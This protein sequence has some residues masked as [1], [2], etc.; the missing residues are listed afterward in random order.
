[1][2]GLFFILVFIYSCG[3]KDTP[4]TGVTQSGNNS[5][6]SIVSSQ[7]E[8][9]SDKTIIRPKV[10]FLFLFDNS[11][12]A[13][14]INQKTKSSLQ[15]LVQYIS[16]RFDYHM[17]IFPLLG[18]NSVSPHLIMVDNP[19]D[20]NTS[21]LP[22]VIPV[23]KFPLIN[24]FQFSQVPGSLENGLI[25]THDILKNNISNGLFRKKAYT[26]VII[27]SS[28]DD[29]L[30]ALSDYSPVGFNTF[31]S[32][33]LNLHKTLATNTLE[34][35]MYRFISVV[36]NHQETKDLC[37][38]KNYKNGNMYRKFSESIYD[39]IPDKYKTTFEVNKKDSYNL[40]QVDFSHIFDGINQ[41]IQDITLHHVY[42]YWPIATTLD[43]QFDP[44]K[45]TVT[46]NTGEV[47][48]EN[49]PNGFKYIG[50][51]TQ[52]NTRILPTPGEPKTAFMIELLGKG[53]VTFPE[54]L[55]V[56][57]QAPA[58]FYNYVVIHEEPNPETLVIKING[59]NI[60]QDQQN[61]WKYE[62]YSL[63]KNIKIISRSNTQ[64][65]Q[66]AL[67]KTG[68]F[69]KL[70]GSAILTNSDTIEFSYKRPPIQ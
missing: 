65:A 44:E 23:N 58:D 1:M 10:D 46:K 40:C 69:V 35:E 37:L 43:P 26:I 2:I 38:S 11:S 28:G 56:K 53:Q 59:K 24:P 8:S 15:D 42:Q 57:T 48:Y 39:S 29:N 16:P 6:A 17:A 33:A 32:N 9:C 62:G 13:N 25:R 27:V 3:K 61:G 14:F 67:I 51:K 20:L 31:L 64:E 66:P 5:I 70:F 52:Q 34:S 49:D 63:S 4:V 47:L 41:T 54:C 18:T 45:I 7:T 21:L 19:S 36:G 30:Y 55:S 12:S 60:N 50:L 68:Y 22:L